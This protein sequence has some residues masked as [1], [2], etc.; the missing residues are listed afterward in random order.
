MNRSVNSVDNRRCPLCGNANQC[1]MAT[2]QEKCWCFTAIIS[3][4]VL[5]RVPEQARDLACICEKCAKL[6]A[7]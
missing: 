6:T 7:I 2:G 3:G 1:G 5:A 4:E